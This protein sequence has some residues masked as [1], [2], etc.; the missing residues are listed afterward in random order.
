MRDNGRVEV[1]V[2]VEEVRAE[3]WDET[4]GVKGRRGDKGEEANSS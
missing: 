4:D 1:E 3:R 2:E